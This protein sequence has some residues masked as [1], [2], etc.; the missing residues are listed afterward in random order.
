MSN[1]ECSHD[2]LELVEDDGDVV[3]MR[4]AF[5]F[6]LFKF[7]KEEFMKL[8]EVSSGGSVTNRPQQALR[9]TVSKTV[10][11]R[12]AED[13]SRESVQ[14]RSPQSPRSTPQARMSP[15]EHHHRIW[16]LTKIFCG[17]GK[18]RRS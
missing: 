18:E 4:C 11:T 8:E 16:G 1:S 7:S 9:G 14:N 6:V 12:R 3:W 13:G 10:E 17:G 15:P 5:C 2:V